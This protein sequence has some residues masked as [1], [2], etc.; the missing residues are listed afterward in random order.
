MR[1]GWRRKFTKET[2]LM[3]ETKEEAE[4]H[5][6]EELRRRDEGGMGSNCG[7]LQ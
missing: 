5:P 7:Q 4:E 1:R 3:K 2:K 6:K